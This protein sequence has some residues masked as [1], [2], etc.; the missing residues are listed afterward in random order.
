MVA[1]VGPPVV[2]GKGEEMSLREERAVA[3]APMSPGMVA[4]KTASG[5]RL[6]SPAFLAEPPT[7]VVGPIYA[8][9][10]LMGLLVLFSGFLIVCQFVRYSLIPPE[11]FDDVS[12]RLLAAGVLVAAPFAIWRIVISFQHSRAAL[13]Q[14]AAA[15][16]QADIANQVHFTTL[17]V[18]AMEQLGATRVL[19][20][21]TISKTEPNTEVRLGAIYA[22][23]RLARDSERDHWSIMETLC[24][25]VRKNAK[26]PQFVSEEMRR[27]LAAGDINGGVLEAKRAKLYVDVQ[28]ALTVI[29]RRASNQITYEE[30]LRDGALNPR[31]YE[32]DLTGVDLSGAVLNGLNFDYACFD[33]SNLAFAELEGTSL[34]RARFWHTHVEGANL[35]GA[36]LGAASMIGHWEGAD[37]SG[38]NLMHAHAQYC[39][40]DGAQFLAADLTQ[41]NFKEAKVRGA[42][43]QGTTLGAACFDYAD[44]SASYFKNVKLAEVALDGATLAS[45]VFEDVECGVGVELSQTQ[46]NEVK[47]NPNTAIAPS[48]SRPEHWPKTTEEWNS[49]LRNMSAVKKAVL[50][51]D[52]DF[53]HP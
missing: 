3:S 28:A 13:V 30:Q 33:G 22:L 32:L 1:T 35:R 23:E 27:D 10:T 46:L 40:F 31:L 15:T 50:A 26:P 5:W 45:A 49:V 24:A 25:Y 38:A 47:G 8:L 48:R 42:Y 19:T 18:N 11:N 2:R 44:L 51:E 34:R 52:D 39:A 9:L 29:G 20:E 16:R 17:F 12:K 7:L 53:T 41:C 43:F 21:G 14:A 4:D 36:N 6:I 37:F